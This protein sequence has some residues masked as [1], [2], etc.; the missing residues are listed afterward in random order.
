MAG[1]AALSLLGYQLQTHQGLAE[2]AA[3]VDMF[4][5]SYPPRIRLSRGSGLR[6][7]ATDLSRLPPQSQAMAS[8]GLSPL[9]LALDVPEGTSIKGDARR[10]LADAAAWTKSP[11]RDCAPDA[12]H[13]GIPG[14]LL[15]LLEPF[16]EPLM[17]LRKGCGALSVHAKTRKQLQG[18]VCL[19]MGRS[20]T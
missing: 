16:L 20:R 19:Q 1:A 18:R 11:P 6:F 13:G 10:A 3:N 2:L 4:K 17:G 15:P 12:G 14:L 8:L 5:V 7:V 9:F